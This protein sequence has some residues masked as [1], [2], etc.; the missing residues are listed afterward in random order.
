[1]MPPGSHPGASVYVLVVLVRV[2]LDG[3][4]SGFVLMCWSRER[5]ARRGEVGDVHTFA[6]NCYGGLMTAAVAETGCGGFFG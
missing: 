5:P 6:F 2:L 3:I 4:D 1:M